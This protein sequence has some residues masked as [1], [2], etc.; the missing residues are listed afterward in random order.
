MGRRQC[1]LFPMVRYS[2]VCLGA[3]PMVSHQHQLFQAKNWD[4]QFQQLGVA[5]LLVECLP[6]FA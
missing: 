5:H 1:C 6:W 4:K 2:L 3:P